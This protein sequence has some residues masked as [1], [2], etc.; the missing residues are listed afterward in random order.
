[1][2][3]PHAGDAGRRFLREGEITGGLEHPGVVPVYGL[4]RDAD[5]QPCYA[6]RFIRGQT[7]QEAI[8][9]FHEADEAGR[10][11]ALRQLLGRFVAVCNTIAYAHS[12]GVI[13]RDLK[14]ANIML[15]DYGETLVVD[16]GLAKRLDRPGEAQPPDGD[17]SPRAAADG[18]TTAP[19]PATC[20][21]RPP[22]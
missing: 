19:R 7:L 18:A 14:P 21:A 2:R 9:R 13:H 5:G 3:R 22:S 11:L 1:M 4:T 17:G 20:W 6:M 10:G 12:R 8:A 16:W 15:G